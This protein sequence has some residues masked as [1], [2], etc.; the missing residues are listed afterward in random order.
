MANA[1]AKDSTLQSVLAGLVG[2]ELERTAFVKEITFKESQFESG[3][4]DRT[5]GTNK[6]ASGFVRT[7]DYISLP[8]NV[9]KMQLFADKPWIVYIL[10]YDAN[11]QYQEYEIN[12][13]GYATIKN[14]PYC[15]LSFFNYPAY[16]SN[17]E[18]ITTRLKIQYIENA[19]VKNEYFLHNHLFNGNFEYDRNGDGIADGWLLRNSPTSYSIEDGIQSITP[20]VAS[21]YI[22]MELDNTR[23]GHVFYCSLTAYT[24][25]D[26][27]ALIAYG[28]SPCR[29]NQNTK[30]TRSSGLVTAVN[31][32]LNAECS[33]GNNAVGHEI[34][35]K[36]IMMIDLTEIYGEGN[37]PTVE[38]IDAIVDEFYGGYVPCEYVVKYDDGDLPV[39][40]M[41]R[42]KNIDTSSDKLTVKNGAVTSVSHY[43]GEE[44]KSKTIINRD[45]FGNLISVEEE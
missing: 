7:S 26:F 17:A 24:P 34:Q 23:T 27:C 6:N 29:V 10:Y 42:L 36:N 2:A 35:L 19:P 11:K 31:S 22:R 39:S 41:E 43:V 12:K 18:F 38:E 25:Y 13:T 9:W 21:S 20:S 44:L 30:F 4:I 14:Y 40:I 37:E 1:L 8:Q 5:T 16:M 45:K 28:S 32:S 15:R 3:D 33:C